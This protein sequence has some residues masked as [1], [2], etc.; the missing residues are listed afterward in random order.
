MGEQ[1]TTEYVRQELLKEDYKLLSDYKKSASKILVR[2]PK[3]HLWKTCWNY[4][5]QGHRCGYCFGRYNVNT[6]KVREGLASKGFALIGEY[7]NASVPI[8]VRCP[9]GHVT[10]LRW[11]RWCS[12]PTCKEC[13]RRPTIT[14][15]KIKKELGLEEYVLLTDSYENAQQHL[16]VKCSKGHKYS[17][18]WTN[19]QQ[20]HR[21]PVCNPGHASNAEKQVVECFQDFGPL[22]NDR[23]ILKGKELDIYFPQQK[24]AIEYCGLYWH[25]TA[26]PGRKIT[27]RYH[28]DK[29]DSCNNLGIRLLTIFEDEW[30]NNK[31][32][33]VSRIK[34]ALGLC[35][36]RVFA[37]H[38]RVKKISKKE[39][40][41]FLEDAHL[42]GYGGCSIAFG[43][44]YNDQLKQVMTFGF[45]TRAHTTQG[46]RVL[47]MKRLAS[48]P[49]CI[50]VGGAG[51]LFKRGLRYAQ[52]N[53]FEVV[54]SY[55][56]LRWG[57]GKL[58]EQ[59]GFSLTNETKYTL[60]YT[61]GRQR[62]FRNQSL[63]TNKKREQTTEME[64]AKARRLYRIYDCGHQ[65]WEFVV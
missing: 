63:A 24:V 23:T 52:Q 31:L 48:V 7:K 62:R 2:C 32:I 37:R 47:E 26:S 22:E 10:R 53:N 12:N 58:Y 36:E 25:S 8:T 43:L 28:R 27:P 5:Q 17:V 15:K 19:W 30:L 44:F 33:C 59:L 21:C 39:A 14:I 4:W 56:D 20:G 11:H 45:P 1:L 35:E 9:K 13:G 18:T 57:T 6:E 29:M 51:K 60:H 41:T 55:C 50:I 54:K 40:K 16:D 65:T 64:K 42:Q 3:G 38:C 46:K 34:N 49:D 61:D